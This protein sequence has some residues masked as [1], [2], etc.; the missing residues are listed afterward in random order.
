[1]GGIL[2]ILVNGMEEFLDSNKSL[3]EYI[4]SKDLKPNMVI[5]EY[6]LNFVSSKEWSNIQLKDNDRIE[7]LR[8][9]GGG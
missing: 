7:I 9:V 6:N 2:K 8:I 5:V 1:M 3:L 4:L